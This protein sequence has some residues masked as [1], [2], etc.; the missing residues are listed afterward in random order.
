MIYPYNGEIDYDFV[1]SQYSQKGF[2]FYD[3]GQYNINL[4]GFRNKDLTVV[5][6]FNDII[7]VAYLDEFMKKQCLIFTGTTKPGL[8]YLKDKLGNPNGTGI[9]CEGYYPKCWTISKHNIGKEHEHDAFR[10]YGPGVFKVWRDKDS[11]GNFDLDG[12]IYTDVQGLNGHTTRD[13]DIENV[14]GFSAACQV[15]QDDKEHQ[16]WLAVGKRSAELYAN[17]FSYAL[18]RQ[19]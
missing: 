5:N 8:T 16:I 1:K 12:P 11:D 6:K 14:G 15:V 4:F 18:F 3:S 2:K 17:L 13:F 9:L 10:Q 19:Q 7:G